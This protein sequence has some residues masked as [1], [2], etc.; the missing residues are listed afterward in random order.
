MKEMVGEE[1]KVG[2]ETDPL[3]CCPS[4]GSISSCSDESY[5][6]PPRRPSHQRY[7]VPSN[8]VFFSTGVCLPPKK[9]TKTCYADNGGAGEPV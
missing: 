5:H 8:M 1:G 6:R 2:A 4:L 3:T 9:M 7:A